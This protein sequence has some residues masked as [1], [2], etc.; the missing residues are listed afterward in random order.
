MIGLDAVEY[1]AKMLDRMHE[2]G[3]A[4]RRAERNLVLPTD[5][6]GRGFI[7]NDATGE[8]EYAEDIDLMRQ[9]D[10]IR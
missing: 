5:E 4:S 2:L 6:E 7:L 9:R 1:H 8:R 10:A 3:R